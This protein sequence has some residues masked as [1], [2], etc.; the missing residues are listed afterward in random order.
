MHDTS[1]MNENL[2][3][4]PM[5]RHTPKPA[6]TAGRACA[7]SQHTV[8]WLNERRGRRESG[9]LERRRHSSCDASGKKSSARATVRARPAVEKHLIPSVGAAADAARP[10]PSGR[11]DQGWRVPHRGGGAWWLPL[12]ASRWGCGCSS[13]PHGRRPRLQLRPPRTRALM[14]NWC[15]LTVSVVRHRARLAFRRPASSAAASSAAGDGAMSMRPCLMPSADRSI[16]G[17]VSRVTHGSHAE[18]IRPRSFS[19]R[20]RCLRRDRQPARGDMG[21]RDP[22]PAGREGMR[23]ETRA[24][25]LACHRGSITSRRR[26]LERSGV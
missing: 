18:E 22:V 13:S 4:R 3:R 17:L 14:H 23:P 10:R 26:S 16:D 12:V 9:S 8:G 5:P 25:T 24:S 2:T 7:H 6:L 20:Q 1:H 21:G 15:L 11:G 19:P